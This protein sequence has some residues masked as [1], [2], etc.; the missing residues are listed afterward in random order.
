MQLSIEQFNIPIATRSRLRA[1]KQHGSEE[2]TSPTPALYPLLQLANQ[3][4]QAQ[5]KQ[6]IEKAAAWG[7]TWQHL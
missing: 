4:L 6:S 3:S 5:S 1:M 2:Q 7:E